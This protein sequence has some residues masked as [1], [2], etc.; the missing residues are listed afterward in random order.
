ME[1][2]AEGLCPA[3]S[4]AA[5]LVLQPLQFLDRWVRREAR[6]LD[7]GEESGS[8]HRKVAHPGI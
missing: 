4:F 5:Q 6:G 3:C 1:P 7:G 2:K 8:I